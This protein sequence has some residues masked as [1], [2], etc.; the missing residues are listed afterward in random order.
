MVLTKVFGVNGDDYFRHRVVT[1][2]F[3]GTESNK[4]IFH[5]IQGCTYIV[6]NVEPTQLHLSF[7]PGIHIEVVGDID[8]DSILLDPEI[9]FVI[10]C[11]PVRR[12][13][14]TR[15]LVNIRSFD[16][17]KEWITKKSGECGFEILGNPAITA[18]KGQAKMNKMYL[19][20]NDITIFG[21]LSVTDRSLFEYSIQNGIG[22]KKFLGFGL[23]NIFID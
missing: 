15:K 3:D 14:K 23:I 9:S 11:N 2:L 19:E 5:S 7:A 8:F 6:S 12:D 4:T 18:T 20:Y 1:A 21:V 22:Q 13:N 16:A 10:R 17:I